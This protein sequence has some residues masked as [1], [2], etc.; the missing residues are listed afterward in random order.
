MNQHPDAAVFPP[1]TDE[2]YARLA[3]SIEQDGLLEPITMHEGLILDGLNRHRACQER[4]VTPRFVEWDASCG[5]TPLEWVINK[6]LHRRQL[7]KAQCA[8]LA[9]ELEPRLAEAARERQGQ[10]TDIMDKSPGSYGAARDIAGATFGVSGRSVSRLKEVKARDEAVFEDVKAGKKTIHA[11]REAV[12]L[13]STSEKVPAKGSEALN[14]ALE[15]LV[16]Y[17]RRWDEQRLYGVTP[18]EARTLLVK[19]QTVDAGLFELERALESRTVV[20]RALS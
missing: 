9:L 11:A 15:P 8:A 3:D 4:G 12:G 13:P 6:N 19:V 18:K 10:R 7:T 16:K 2:E 1:M 5:L 20:S 14:D 17:L